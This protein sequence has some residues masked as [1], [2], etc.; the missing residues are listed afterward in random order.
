MMKS[1][2]SSGSGDGIFVFQG[3]FNVMS[4]AQSLAEA[5]I[6][7]NV[8]LMSGESANKSGSIPRQ[9]QHFRIVDSCSSKGKTI[10]DYWNEKW[11]LW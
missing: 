7:R 11:K 10:K 4:S 8:H 2:V 9:K 1:L 3:M 6:I 5:P